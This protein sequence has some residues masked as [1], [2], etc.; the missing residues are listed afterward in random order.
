VVLNGRLAATLG[1]LV[2]RW[3]EGLLFWW[4]LLIG[5]GGADPED[6]VGESGQIQDE[7][8]E[9][10]WMQAKTKLEEDG[11]SSGRTVG[12]RPWSGKAREDG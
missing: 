6:K 8:G 12:C 11:R 10:G 7:A 2:E 9:D 5:G 1:G 3:K 4:P